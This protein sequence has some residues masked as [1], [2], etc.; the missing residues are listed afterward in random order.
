LIGAI[1][2]QSMKLENP[3]STPNNNEQVSEAAAQAELDNLIAEYPFLTEHPLNRR[4]IEDADTAITA[5]RYAQEQIAKRHKT[6]LDVHAPESLRMRIN[7]DAVHYQIE[8]IKKNQ[9]LVGEGGDAWVV[10]DKSELRDL[11]PEICYKLYKSE[12]LKR[13]RNSLQQEHAIHE[14]VYA[15][16]NNSPLRIKAPIP[17]Y[18]LEQ[19]ADKLIAMEKLS[20]VSI[21]DLLRGKGTIPSWFDIDEFCTQLQMAIQCLHSNNIYHRDL[22]LGNVMIAQT[23]IDEGGPL[24]YIIDFGLSCEAFDEQFAYQKE[25][26]G[27]VFTY[28][29]DHGIVDQA[30]SSLQSIRRY[31]GK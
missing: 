2:N 20:A 4:R 14:R 11:P 3:L 7:P 30:R 18:T 9:I 29:D 19:G 25:L 5:L 10:M 28:S 12:A 27:S 1:L 8:S 15:I 26:A 6:S 22:H 13:G 24:G 17:F 16:L 31:G 23:S 21:D